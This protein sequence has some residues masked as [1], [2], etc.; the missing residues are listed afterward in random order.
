MSWFICYA[1]VGMIVA[2]VASVIVDRFRVGPG[3]GPGAGLALLVASVCWP[4]IM[5]G[6]AQTALWVVAVELAGG[7]RQQKIHAD[8]GTGVAAR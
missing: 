5:I 1:V 8:L 2:A 7:R 6:A 3:P 4:V